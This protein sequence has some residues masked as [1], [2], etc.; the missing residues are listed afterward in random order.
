MKRSASGLTHTTV[1]GSHGQTCESTEQCPLFLTLNVDK[2]APMVLAGSLSRI[3][4]KPGCTRKLQ[5]FDES[6]LLH[7]TRGFC[8]CMTP[9]EIDR[10]VCME[11][12]SRELVVDAF[13]YLLP[14]M[15]KYGPDIILTDLELRLVVARYDFISFFHHVMETQKLEGDTTTGPDPDLPTLESESYSKK[16]RLDLASYCSKASWD[17]ICTAAVT[18][19]FRLHYQRE[20]FGAFQHTPLTQVVTIPDFLFCGF[21]V[22]PDNPTKAIIRIDCYLDCSFD[23]LLGVMAETDMTKEWVPYFRFP[24]HV[25]LENCYTIFEMGRFDKITFYKIVLPWPF[26]NVEVYLHGWL[27]DDLCANDRMC[28]CF[29]ALDPAYPVSPELGGVTGPPPEAKSTRIYIDGGCRVKV[30][31]DNRVKMEL[32]WNIDLKMSIPNALVKFVA[33]TFVKTGIS[34]LRGLCVAAQTDPAWIERRKKSPWLY[35]FLHERFASMTAMSTRAAATS[36]PAF[37][38]RMTTKTSSI[39]RKRDYFR[40]TKVA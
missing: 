18:E 5:P 33:K 28:I 24:L 34:A 9:L 7:T 8:L 31:A 30:E 16:R 23:A 22:N 14:M 11:L 38:K 40:R 26:S 10:Q 4:H 21:K 6:S 3:S 37:E 25:G 2:A 15:D 35:E 12:L 1:S 20:F 19:N 27:A 17:R 32:L 29:R 39:R 13:F 36:S